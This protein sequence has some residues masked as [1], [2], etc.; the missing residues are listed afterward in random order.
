MAEG[1]SSRDSQFLK[2]R[3]LDSM[4][5]AWRTGWRVPD[6]RPIYEWASEFVTLPAGVYAIQG[7]FNVFHSRFLIKPFQALQSDRV[8]VVT[9][10]APVRSGKTLLADVWLPWTLIN[11]PGPF[12]WNMSTDTLARR[13]SRTRAL[14]LLRSIDALRALLPEDSRQQT[15]QEIIFRNGVPFYIQ[16]PS[17]DNLQGVGVRYLVE[18]EVW[19]RAAGRHQEAMGRLGDYQKINASKMLVIGQAG[20]EDDDMDMEFLEGSQE[21][22]TVPCGSCGK[23]FVPVSTGYRPDG[24]RFGLVWGTPQP[25][26]GNSAK[27]KNGNWIKSRVMETVRYAAPCCGFEHVDCARTLVNWNERGEYMVQNHDAPESHKSFHLYATVTRAW[28]LLA[29]DL[30][31]ALNAYRSGILDLLITYTQKYDAN[32]WSESLVMNQLKAP[33]YTIEIGSDGKKK[34]WRE[35]AERIMT[36]D[37]QGKHNWCL[38]FGASRTGEL[39]RLFYGKALDKHELKK[40]Q[41]EWGVKAKRVFV[42]CS[43]EAQ[44]VYAWCCEFG[45]FGLNGDPKKNFVHQIKLK[46]KLKAVLRSYSAPRRGDP[47]NGK[48]G[49]GR[50]FA[51]YF[52]W[53]NPTIRARVMGLIEK[54]RIVEPIDVDQS[55]E[56]ELAYR[57]QMRGQWRKKVINKSTGKVKFQDKENE[58]DHARDCWN[59]GVTALTMLKLLPDIEVED[60]AGGAKEEVKEEA[61]VSDI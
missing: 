5:L 9:M 39:R 23:F 43:W 25:G 27:D 51:T 42:D 24:S 22:F 17:I 20:I 32:S 56:M 12:M 34:P 31:L 41:D 38:I 55:D 54:G 47:E 33:T 50:R 29:E 36:V 49:A 45:W 3:A 8:R 37:K 15:G 40:L 35:E 61:A 13:H 7:K 14:P 4:A 18:D 58:E 2:A 28:M 30:A 10:K 57:K 16:G 52:H 44:E 1:S 60:V 26:G 53:S 46:G 21:E 19:R 11:A 6:R 48:L 59:M